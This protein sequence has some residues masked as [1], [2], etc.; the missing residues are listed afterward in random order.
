M[1][2]AA[3][4]RAERRAAPSRPAIPL[5]AEPGH[6]QSGGLFVPGEGLGV[7]AQ[8]GLQGRPMYSSAKG[9]R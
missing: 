4:R 2:S 7:P 3:S 6:K 1:R 8:R 5:G 9:L